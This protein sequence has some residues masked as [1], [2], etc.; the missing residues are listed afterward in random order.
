MHIISC[1]RELNKAWHSE[2][3]EKNIIKIAF[4]KLPPPRAKGFFHLQ[5]VKARKFWA[6]PSLEKGTQRHSKHTPGHEYKS[7]VL[8]VSELLKHSQV[9]W[10]FHGPFW[11]NTP[12]QHHLFRDFTGF[13]LGGQ[14]VLVPK[15][16]FARSIPVQKSAIIDF[17]FGNIPKVIVPWK[18]TSKPLQW[19]TK[20]AASWEEQNWKKIVLNKCYYLSFLIVYFLPNKCKV[21]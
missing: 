19:L 3:L 16:D 20:E 7:S 5:Q 8:V 15:Q 10:L 11:L 4:I 12:A 1:K 13:V 9:Y 17:Y 14:E 21:L 2:I 6:V 18:L